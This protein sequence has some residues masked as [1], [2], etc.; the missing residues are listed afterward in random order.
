MDSRIAIARSRCRRVN[1][2]AS[3][4][5]QLD[6]Q[7]NGTENNKE[8]EEAQITKNPS[9]PLFPSVKKIPV[10]CRGAL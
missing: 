9:L 8:N 6:D 3:V 2:G 10:C 1:F 7:K 5:L 4:R